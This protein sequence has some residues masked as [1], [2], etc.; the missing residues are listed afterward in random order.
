MHSDKKSR[1][2]K[3]GTAL[4][5]DSAF[6]GTTLLEKGNIEIETTDIDSFVKENNLNIGFIKADVEGQIIPLIKGAKILFK[7][8][9]GAL[10]G[11]IPFASGIFRSKTA[12]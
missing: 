11:H 1:F 9:T 6:Q 12:A 3:K 2:R 10:S 5:N 4:I 7:T 8:Q